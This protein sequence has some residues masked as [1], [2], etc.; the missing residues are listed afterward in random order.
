MG[1]LRIFP[2]ALALVV[3]VWA[4]PRVSAQSA[5]GEIG[6]IVQDEQGGLLPGVSLTLRHEA[7]GVVRSTV[8]ED[9]GGYRFGGLPPGVYTLRAELA[10]FSIQEVTGIEIT[11][12]LSL[13]RDFTL[14][15]ESLREAITVHAQAPVVDTTKAE[16]SGVV[17]QRQIETLPINSRQYLSLALLMPGTSLDSTRAFFPTVNVGGSMTFNSTANVV[18]GVIN[19]FAE[20]GEPRQNLPQDAV[21]EFKVSNGQF[22]AELGLATGGAVQVVTKSG[23]NIVHGNVFE[24]LRDKSLNARNFFETAKPEYRRDQYGGSLGGPVR[25]D[26]IHYFAAVERTSIDEFFTVSTGFPQYYGALEGTFAKPSYRNLYFARVDWQISNS[27]TAFARYAH[28]DE[29]STCGGC[30][31]TVAANAGFDQETPRR[32]LVV[33]H[34]WIRGSRQL[35]DLRFQYARAGYYIAP[36][37]TEIS[38]D[39]GS[40]SPDRISRQVI[41]LQFPSLT[42]GSNFDEVGPESRWQL[43]DTYSITMARHEFRTGVDISYMPYTEQVANNY[44]GAYS[45]SRDQFFDPNVPSSVANLTG[46]TSFSAQLPPISTSRPTKY[47]V[48][49]VQDDWKPRRDLTLSLGLRYERLYGCC[50]EDLDP[51][52]FPIP[53]PYIDVS[54]RG[55]TNNFGPR[56]GL[57]WDARRD[58]TTVVRA[59]WG[60]YYGHVRILQNLNEFRNYKRFLVNIS[61]PAYPDPYGGKDPLTYVSTAPANITVVA[62][63]YVQPYSHQFS[64]GISRQL[65]GAFALH[66]DALYTNT[67]HDRKILDINPRDPVTRARPNPVFG[68]VDR[69]QSTGEVRYRALYTR[70][71]RR[72]LNRTQFTASYSYVN[73]RDNNPGNRYLDPFDDSLDWGP[74]NGERRHALVASGSMLLPWD[75][76]FGA[77]WTVRSQLP[78]SATAGRDLNGDGFNT[79]LVPGLSRNTGSR[80]LDLNAV[81]VWRAANARAPI[82]EDQI[83][84]SA[85]NLVDV[86]AAKR[87]RL[88]RRFSAEL[89]LQVFNLFNKTNFQ[90]QYGGGRIGNTLSDRFGRIQ[91]ARPARQGELAARVTW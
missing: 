57:A 72:F 74:S 10:G 22:K 64:A 67:K 65:P 24:Y 35:N 15:V 13:R 61:S 31:G 12:G 30:G 44:R 62:N 36:A 40:F 43:K 5:M 26:R 27:H 38:R 80:N 37:G 52:I 51:S 4:V 17:T 90:D 20:D 45:F 69:N 19:N 89:T 14:R 68:R 50:N 48:G 18:D 49:F 39:I 6:G 55:D 33:G 70:L 3:V 21:E 79:D 29:K 73:S 41:A 34:T 76:T 1:G 59:G 53:I 82:S 16:V 32:S 66:V 2:V 91:T 56:V 78:W 83:D 23:T 11:I 58:G 71:D 9:D 8:A 25:R 54:K 84:S 88:S 46:A 28:E 60:M 7:S 42:W 75:V 47:Y 85:I 86:R 63:D 87:L 81:N 77:L